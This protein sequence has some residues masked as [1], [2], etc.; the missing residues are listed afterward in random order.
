MAV[1]RALGYIQVGGRAVERRLSPP[2]A[3]L[4]LRVQ[5]TPLKG[6]PRLGFGLRPRAGADAK[7]MPFLT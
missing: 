6:S 5:P 3:S 7:R 2:L 1:R 4:A